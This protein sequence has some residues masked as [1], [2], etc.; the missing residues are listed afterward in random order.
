MSAPGTQYN[1]GSDSTLTF[2]VNGAPVGSMLLTKFEFKQ[3]T[4]RLVS[5]PINSPPN[6]RDLEEGW[7]GTLV[8]D[9]SNSV[10]D[11]FFAAKEAARWAGQLPPSLTITTTINNVDGTTSRYR[12]NNVTAKLDGG[13][14]YA[15]DEK[16][17][18]TA[19]W[20]ASTRTPA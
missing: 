14:T 18:Q 5:K 9:R 6:Y 8:Y 1:I 10:L 20:A 7:E 2:L 16:V 13:G 12:F 3:N 17:E 15:A 11:D 4:T 19:S